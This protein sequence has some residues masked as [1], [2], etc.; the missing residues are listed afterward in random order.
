MQQNAKPLIDDTPQYYQWREDYQHICRMGNL[1]ARIDD[2]LKE[3]WTQRSFNNGYAGEYSARLWKTG[4]G[5]ILLRLSPSGSVTEE[6]IK[7][8]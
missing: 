1:L 4:Q 8:E 7:P 5:E 2:K 6:A 3:G